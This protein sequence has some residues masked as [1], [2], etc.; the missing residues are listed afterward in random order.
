MIDTKLIDKAK[1]ESI[2]IGKIDSS[3]REFVDKLKADIF[4]VPFK[5]EYNCLIK[6]ATMFI[7]GY[8]GPLLIDKLYF[9]SKMYILKTPVRY[10]PFKIYGTYDEQGDF[11]DFASIPE[12]GVHYLGLTDKGHAICTGEIQYIN[13][14]S[15]GL[16]KEACLKIAKSL[17]VINLES[18]GAVILPDVYLSLKNIL[19]NKEYDSKKKFEKLIEEN[20]IE[21]II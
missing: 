20:L 8:S 7:E 12:M 1:K 19:S 15:L 4:R 10:Y 5:G 6:D 11:V 17:R 9:G 18:M 21:E 13:P 16:L 2:V 14:E 3:W